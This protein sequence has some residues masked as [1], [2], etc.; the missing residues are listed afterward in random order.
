MNVDFSCISLN[1]RGLRDIT[2]RKS[3]FLFCK[4]EKA[5]FILLQETHSKPDDE[6]FWIN[7]LGDK[8]ILTMAP[9]DQLGW[10]FFSVTLLV[11]WWPLNLVIMVTG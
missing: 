6:K 1:A 10:P 3:I 4:C 8:I 5:N 11:N 7:Q 2:K 9:Q